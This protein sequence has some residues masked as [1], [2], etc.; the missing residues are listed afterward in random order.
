MTHPAADA[1]P[2]PVWTPRRAL[3]YA[4]VGLPLAFVALP[5]Y[6][7]LPHHY[8]QALGVPL[9]ALGAVLLAVRCLDA[10]VDPA[11]GRWADRLLARS[12]GAAWWTL[13]GAALVIG[14]GFALLFFPPVLG[15]TGL[16]L[17]CA[18]LLTLTCAAWSL[19][20][21]LHQ[22]WGARLG[23]G[24][25]GQSRWVA[26]REAAGVL[27]V[28]IASVLPSLAGLAVTVG[29]LV[30]ALGVGWLLLRHA[31][32]ATDAFTARAAATCEGLAPAQAGA[33]QEAPALSPW[34]VPAFRRLLAVFVLN[35]IAS[36]LPAT[37]VLF[38]IR[39][40]LQAQVWEGAFL[41]IYF[42][43]GA[44]S[45]PLWVRAVRRW[46]AVP[47]WALG[48]VLAVL[49]FA[50]A[51]L[52]GPGDAAWYALICLASGLALGA[53][54][55][56]PAALLARVVQAS[57]GQ[58]RSEGLFFG[59]WNCAAKLNLA[60]AAGVALPLLGWAGYVPGRSD[61]QALALLAWAY[62]G[63]P[64]AIKLVALVTLRWGLWSPAFPGGAV[65]RAHSTD[66]DADADRVRL[67]PARPS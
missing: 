7:L 13:G 22:A 28:V 3:A 18:L 55:A 38:Y 56:I 60:L 10:V 39:D 35:G 47:A 24:V 16:L 27:G 53:D 58:G 64:C 34:S 61:P 41:A 32:V 17:W 26:S 11:L 23:G 14:G 51:A 9:A 19:A 15:S 37:L 54:L 66:A 57:G 20:T 5:L 12:G 33:A 2:E 29:V 44:A 8:A 48:M 59:W 36:A 42:V 45:L 43:A 30:L 4:A 65:S 25:A 1:L 62:G 40:R 21:V 49:G 6:V 50:S 52:L 63:L 67:R 31:P 46:G